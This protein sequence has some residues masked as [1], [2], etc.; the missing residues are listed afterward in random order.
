MNNVN[1]IDDMHILH[2]FNNVLRLTSAPEVTISV[3][4]YG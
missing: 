3:K 2:K 4:S 1:A